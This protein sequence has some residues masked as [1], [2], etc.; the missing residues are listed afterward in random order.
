MHWLIRRSVESFLRDIYGDVVWQSLRRASDDAMMYL[1]ND[2]HGRDLISDA[3][4]HLDKPTDD[5]LDDLGAWIARQ[6]RM[7]RLFRFSGGSF[8]EFLE[9]LEMLPDRVSTVLPDFDIPPMQI[10]SAD[11]DFVQ[12]S[13]SEGYERWAHV[14]AGVVR[15]M[16]DDYGVLGL[17]YVEAEKVCVQICDGDFG[18][19]RSLKLNC[20]DYAY[21]GRQI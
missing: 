10:F 19:K 2:W 5:M 12:I 1:S 4:R 16:A 11:R 7:R 8:R 3:A 9:N 18:E 13:L 15:V 20:K 6:E 14:L 17:V 21:G